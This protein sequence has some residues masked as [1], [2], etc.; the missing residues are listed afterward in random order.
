MDAEQ[1]REFEDEGYTLYFDHHTLTV[2]MHI[3]FVKF[4]SVVCVL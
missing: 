4:I 3:F 2:R 1:Q